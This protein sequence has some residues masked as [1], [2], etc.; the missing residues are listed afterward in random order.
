V[1]ERRHRHGAEQNDVMTADGGAISRQR[2]DA[3]DALQGLFAR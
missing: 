1:L 2:L 3:A